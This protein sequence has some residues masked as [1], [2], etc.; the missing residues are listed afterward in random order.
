[1]PRTPLR[2]Y[3]SSYLSTQGLFLD[4]RDLDNRDATPNW[5]SG[6]LCLGSSVVEGRCIP[7]ADNHN[8]RHKLCHG[9]TRRL[10]TKVVCTVVK[11]NKHP[12]RGAHPWNTAKGGMPR[13]MATF[14]HCKP[15]MLVCA[16]PLSMGVARNVVLFLGIIFATSVAVHDAVCFTPPKPLIACIISTAP[17]AFV[18]PTP[19]VCRSHALY[20]SYRSSSTHR[21]PMSIVQKPHGLSPPKLGPLPLRAS[22]S[23]Y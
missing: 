13:G 9:P 4:N 21:W 20:W 5:G 6:P 1:M 19:V 2:N 8:A 10:H 17:T 7:S 23:L 18:L 22:S 3:G 11:Q 14:T 16:A 12:N 15:Q